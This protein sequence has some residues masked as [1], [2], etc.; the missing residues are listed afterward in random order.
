L[1]A[2]G[3]SLG[4]RRY[5]Q[6][7]WLDWNALRRDLVAAVRDLLPGA[8]LEPLASGATPGATRVLASIPAQLVPGP[9]PPPPSAGDSPLALSLL[10]AWVSV[11]VAALAV[12]VLLLGVLSLSERRAAF[13]SAV[14]HELRT[15]L[16][17]F[18]LYTDLLADDMVRDPEKKKAYLLTLRREAERLGHLVENVLAY[19][20]LERGARGRRLDPVGLGELIERCRPRLDERATAAGFQLAI[21]LPAGADRRVLG[22]DAAAVEQI[23]FNLVDN[24]CKYAV[25]ATDRRLTMQVAAGARETTI[26][27]AD[28]GP[29]IP[30][31][32]ARRLFVP[33]SRSA[34]Q[35]SGSAPGVGLGLA[36][37]RQ[38]ARQLGGDLFLDAAG[39]PGALFV[40]TLPGATAR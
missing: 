2:R 34:E 36:L 11:A 17:T 29:G 33:F 30:R 13:V 28:R 9:V 21:A 39:G 26:S 1:L 37:S 32:E 10:A 14:T 4:G 12:G 6:G 16:T 18:R 15:P 31:R 25:G 23:L 7:C 20:R 27:L 3:V 22:T 40:L 19:A 24:A 38:L 35:A 8:A 5:V